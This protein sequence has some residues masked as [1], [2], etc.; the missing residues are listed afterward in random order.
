MLSWFDTKASA[1][2]ARELAE[3]L[4]GSLLATSAVRDAKFMAKAEKALIRADSKVRTF[5][6]RE[7]MNVFK[8][9]KL[10]NAFLWQLKDRGCPEDYA[11][12]L[13]QWLTLRL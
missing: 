6:A 7:R 5:R 4:M 13:T 12:E 2:F 1:L 9:A 3:D 8:K 11:E 10:A